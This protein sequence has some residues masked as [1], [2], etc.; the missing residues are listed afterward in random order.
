MS[1]TVSN[2]RVILSG[3]R[4]FIR[5]LQFALSAR[6]LE[7]TCQ[8]LILLNPLWS[9]RR[10]KYRFLKYPALVINFEQKGCGGAEVRSVVFSIFFTQNFIVLMVFIA[11]TLVTK[12]LN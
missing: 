9:S 8:V 6:N 11:L 4:V 7:G 1:Y 2:R 12:L 3:I 10:G 5:E